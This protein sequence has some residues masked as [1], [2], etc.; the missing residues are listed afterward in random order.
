M[1]AVLCHGF[2]GI[3]GIDVCVENVGGKLF[4]SIARLMRWNGRL[5]PIGFAGGEIPTIP[6]NLP[7]LKNY[8]IVGVFSGAGSEKFPE[9]HA[10]A[11]D[12]VM[13]W[14]A[15]GRLRPCVDRILP[16]ERVSEAMQAIAERTARGRIVL[17]VR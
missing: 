7:L 14:I 8:S 3:E 6:M 12:T 2:D 5:M 1:R 15:E 4:T 10:R 11:A 13:A 16:P 9:E 17:Q